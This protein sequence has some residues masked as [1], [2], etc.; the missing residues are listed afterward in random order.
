LV[1]DP[2]AS[3]PLPFGSMP[4]SFAIVTSYFS[5]AAAT[6]LLFN[7]IAAIYIIIILFLFVY[8]F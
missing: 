7:Q 5:G 4:F 2:A 8:F 3:R 1:I 6:V